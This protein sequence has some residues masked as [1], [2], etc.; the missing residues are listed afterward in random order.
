MLGRKLMVLTVM[1]CSDNEYAGKNVPWLQIKLYD[2]KAMAAL[3]VD[4]RTFHDVHVQSL[5][6]SRHEEL[7]VHLVNLEKSGCVDRKVG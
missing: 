3:G 1:S 5:I 2:L 6:S 4:D 7:P